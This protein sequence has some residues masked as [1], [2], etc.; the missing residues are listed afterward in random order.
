M[1]RH[2]YRGLGIGFATA[3][4]FAGTALAD[5]AKAPVA[6]AVRSE[7]AKNHAEGWLGVMVVRVPESL[8]AQL[9]TDKDALLVENMVKD[10]PAD[11]A[12]LARF[13]V[14]TKLDGQ[15]VDEDF[16]ETLRDKG[17][18]AEVELAVIHEGQPQTV[19]VTLGAPPADTK[20]K[21][22][23]HPKG[24]VMLRDQFSINGKILRPDGHGGYTLEDL[25][26]W[27][28]IERFT[29]P[30]PPP[31]ESVAPGETQKRIEDA[32]SRAAQ[33]LRLAQKARRILDGEPTT[34]PCGHT[35][36]GPAA[37]TA[38]SFSVDSDGRVT[39]TVRHGDSEITMHFDSAEQFKRKA[40]E[41]FQ[42]YEDAQKL[43]K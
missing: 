23:Y 39:A 36:T 25:G 1:I 10:G 37:R 9:K 38:W 24:N 26:K 22:K 21:L 8:Q 30:P 4:I 27:P 35:D 34:R 43:I 14:I 16:V 31:G 11:R 32:M 13:D 6:E 19:R 18:G 33:Q 15:A 20:L 40:P 2:A 29:M 7:P 5:D 28:M 12:G 17:A 3:L 41:L 42:R